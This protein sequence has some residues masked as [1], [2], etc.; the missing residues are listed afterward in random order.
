MSYI[1]R[2]LAAGEEIVYEGR[3]HFFQ[4]VLPWLA[5]LVLGILIIGIFIWAAELIRMGTTKWAVTNRRVMLKRG[6]WQVRMD[7]L[8]LGSIEGA[9][10]DQSI[11]GRMFGYGKLILH[12]RGDTALEFPTMDKPA[13]FRA[14]ME[15]ARM[16]ETRTIEVA[17]AEPE[18]PLHETRGEH[19]RRLREERRLADRERRLH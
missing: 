7:E 11:F 13:R 4:K 17:P 14:A 12:G 9:H 10:V 6:F 15:D 8:T 2:R 1:S 16:Q 19:K 5:L 18:P 3:F